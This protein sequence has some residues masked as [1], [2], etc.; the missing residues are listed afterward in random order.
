MRA[1]EVFSCAGGMAEGFRRAGVHFALVVD[2]DADAVESY[3]TN[4]GHRP[5]R[6]DARDLLRLIDGGWR[7][8]QRFDLVVA[9]PPCTPW[10][11]AGH[12]KGTSDERD[13]LHETVHLIAALRPR[14]YLIGNV[15]GL[16][17]ST[18]WPALQA[19]LDPLRRA[20]YCIRDFATLDAADFGVPQHRVRPFW[21]GHLDG[22]C[23]RWPS[24]T[25]AAPSEAAH[26]RLDDVVLA[27]WVTCRE[28]LS[29]LDAKDV[30]RPV[31][32][33][34]RAQNSA[35][36]GS[37]LERPARVV[38]TSNLSDGNVLLVHPDHNLSAIDE[39]GKT[40]TRNTHGDGTI[41]VSER[42]APA[43][44]DAP[45]PT[46][47]AKDRCQAGSLLAREGGHESVLDE[48][49][50]TVTGRDRRAST[51]LVV[52]EQ[53]GH[54]M[55]KA[56]EPA[57]TLTTEGVRAGKRASVVEGW[58]WERP[59][60][61]VTT[62]EVVAPGHHE[63]SIRSLEG[64]IVLS[65]KAAAILQGFPVSWTFHGK[66]K[67]ARWSQIGQAMPPALAH[68]VAAAVVAQ[69]VAEK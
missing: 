3:T 54:P 4:L 46:I 13:M 49:A 56:D 16:E 15:P 17:D 63:S 48:P 45:S 50:R 28:A 60:T 10:S 69:M 44:L 66:T 59:S 39:P 8:E 58:P 6:M 41:L 40:I 37:V 20:G 43:T 27:P 47:E 52:G 26:P 61:T 18:Q 55:S 35:Q 9:D 25:H 36:H 5:V 11:R 31:H 12:R 51:L 24:A 67:R 32:L 7:P 29:V 1:M 19:A 38:G 65:E 2:K 42:H 23:L 64:A 68:A 30:G 34:R 57:M 14:A 33:R 21:F 62:R 22:P 53:H